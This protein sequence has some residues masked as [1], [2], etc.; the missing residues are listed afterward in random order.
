VCPPWRAKFEL[1]AQVVICAFSCA[2]SLVQPTRC[3][4]SSSLPFGDSALCGK[5]R[6][7]DPLMA[8]ELRPF[9]C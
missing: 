6:G 2:A 1:L 9:G 8:I 4:R 5:H 7:A 3:G